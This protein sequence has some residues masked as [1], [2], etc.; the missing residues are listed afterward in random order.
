MSR[1]SSAAGA[2]PTS[3]GNP[4]ANRASERAN[5]LVFAAAGER[6]ASWQLARRGRGGQVA[7][8][9]HAPT[10]R[11]EKT[12]SCAPALVCPGMPAGFRVSRNMK[13]MRLRIHGQ[14]DRR[15]HGSLAF[16]HAV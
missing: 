16:L 13:K 11:G 12:R 1:G 5:D 15:C 9:L 3:V 14:D 10:A 6:G 8:L 4:C 2:G 7:N